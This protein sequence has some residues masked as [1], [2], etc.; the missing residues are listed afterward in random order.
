MEQRAMS[1]LF[2]LL[3]NIVAVDMMRWSAV[4]ISRWIGEIWGDVWP[5]GLLPWQGI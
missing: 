1:L 3:R 2:S 4:I 5:G